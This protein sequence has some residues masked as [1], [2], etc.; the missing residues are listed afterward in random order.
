MKALVDIKNL[1]LPVFMLLA[2]LYVYDAWRV[3]PIIPFIE[4][5][6]NELYISKLIESG[7]TRNVEGRFDR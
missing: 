1:L 3:R 5:T 7:S 2:A 6:F 4:K